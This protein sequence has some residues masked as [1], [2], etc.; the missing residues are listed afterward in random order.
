MPTARASPSGCS[1][2]RS[3]RAV[4]AYLLLGMAALALG[5]VI[6]HLFV[7]ANPGHLARA[8]RWAGAVLLGLLA[9]V[10][11][12]GGRLSL[13]A[14]F[15]AG[16][17]GLIGRWPA[18]LPQFGFGGGAGPMWKNAG[19]PGA[20]AGQDSAVETEWLRMSLEH[21]TGAMTGLVLKGPFEGR[22]LAEL[23]FD[24][25]LGLLA[26]CRRHDNQ[27][28]AL[29]ETYLDRTAGED[30]RERQARGGAGGPVAGGLTPQAAR[31]ILGVGPEAGADEIRAAYHRL[32][33]K[34]HPDQSGS[35]FLASQIN[36]AKDLLLGGGAP[37]L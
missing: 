2:A 33:K 31:E 25:L 21:D 30:W 14:A 17:L 10:M 3:A 15:G 7:N 11:L 29:L 8:L 24:G 37:G 32:M 22:Y 36:A 27:A 12:A 18:W 1:P 4:P 23:A 16:A 5:A 6:L 34:L 26:D 9:L 19:H 28:A 13:A 20:A 35:T